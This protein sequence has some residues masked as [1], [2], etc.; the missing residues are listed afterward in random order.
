MK[1]YAERLQHA[2]FYR[3]LRDLVTVGIH[4]YQDKYERGRKE[5]TPFVRMKSIPAGM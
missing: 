1:S 4:R 5:G 2:E 3:Q